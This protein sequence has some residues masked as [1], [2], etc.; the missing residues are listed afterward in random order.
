MNAHFALLALPLPLFS[1]F[2]YLIPP[3]LAGKIQVGSLV[4]VEFK[5]R[6]LL[7]WVVALQEESPRG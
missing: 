2:S 6:R 1:E 7:G 4:E 5:N 3:S